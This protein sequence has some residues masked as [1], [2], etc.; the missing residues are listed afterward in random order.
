M[1]A[2]ILTRGMEMGVAV[3]TVMPMGDGNPSL[4]KP[5]PKQPW[6]P[7]PDPIDETAP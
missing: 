2:V 5:S 7:S 6:E 1:T 3:A 4:L